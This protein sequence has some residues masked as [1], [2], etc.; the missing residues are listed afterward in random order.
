MVSSRLYAVP[1][2]YTSMSF[3]VMSVS[4]TS[5]DTKITGSIAPLTSMPSFNGSLV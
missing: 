1:S 2:G 5:L 4:F 3:T